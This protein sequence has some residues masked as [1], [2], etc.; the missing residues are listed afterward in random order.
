MGHMGRRASCGGNLRVHNGAGELGGEAKILRS[1]GEV[2]EAGDAGER[3][4]AISS[5]H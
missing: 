1:E 2:D 4:V 3:D 5:D